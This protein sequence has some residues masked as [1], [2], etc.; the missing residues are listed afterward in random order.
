MIK[1]TITTLVIYLTNDPI[2]GSLP[3][4]IRYFQCIELEKIQNLEHVQNVYK[5]MTMSKTCMNSIYASI[6]EQK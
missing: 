3:K 1:L 5:S 2:R 6:E 4:A